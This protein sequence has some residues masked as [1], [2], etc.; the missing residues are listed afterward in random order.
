MLTLKRIRFKK[1][2]QQIDLSLEQGKLYSLFGRNG[3]GKTTLLK[4]ITR[5]WE[6]GEGVALLEWARFKGPF[7]ERA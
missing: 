6:P 7:A 3:A 1:V 5:I 2:L 4:V